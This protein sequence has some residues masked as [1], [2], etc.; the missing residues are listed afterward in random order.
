MAS[1]RLARLHRQIAARECN[2]AVLRMPNAA[3]VLVPVDSPRFSAIMQSEP[4]S[5]RVLG[6]FAPGVSLPV[7]CAELCQGVARA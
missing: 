2:Q 6:V 3:F 1:T 7:L 5:A 4:W